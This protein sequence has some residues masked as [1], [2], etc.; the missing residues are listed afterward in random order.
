MGIEAEK[1]VP[2]DGEADVALS[3]PKDAAIEVS[4][5]TPAEGE[6]RE[7][8]TEGFD[9]ILDGEDGS[10]PKPKR[11]GF[12]HRVNK[13]NGKIAVAEENNSALAQ[14]L[15]SERQQRALEKQKADLLQLALEQERAN[16]APAMPDPGN[17][18]DGVNDPRYQQ[19]FQEHN[20]QTNQAAIQEEVRRITEPILEQVKNA[21]P[22][23]NHAIS[24]QRQQEHYR[25]A[26]ELGAS[27]YGEM[28][29]AVISSMGNQV[30]R[31]MVN[32][33]KQP[34]LLIYYLGKNPDKAAEI[35]GYLKQ[36]DIRGV[37]EIGALDDR[38]KAR[39]RANATAAPDP[40]TELSGGTPASSGHVLQVK[41]DKL[42]DKASKAE[43]AA[44]RSNVM[45]EIRN[46]RKEMEAS[47]VAAS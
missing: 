3:D 24:E 28:E 33:C 10:Q 20:K 16:K 5:D 7:A 26:E 1:A 32:K 42:R 40:D 23:E 36:S 35:A 39:P 22:P 27:D 44:G 25:K 4:T 13:L 30:V 18:D 12:Q 46:V 43:S 41:L 6:G 2:K 38:L 29:D 11:N 9:V 19:A 8:A 15:E 45:A 34:H 21:V 47:G 31:E 17:F 37:L 14:E